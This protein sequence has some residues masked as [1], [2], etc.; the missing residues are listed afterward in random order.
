MIL[1]QSSLCWARC[2]NE[3]S[4][5][6]MSFNGEQFSSLEAPESHEWSC[7]RNV[8]QEQE[9]LVPI[10]KQFKFT[11]SLISLKGLSWI[12]FLCW[13]CNGTL[14]LLLLH[15]LLCLNRQTFRSI[16]PREVLWI[17]SLWRAAWKDQHTHQF[18]FPSEHWSSSSL[19]SGSARKRPLAT[20]G[21]ARLN[22][23]EVAVKGCALD[24]MGKRQIFNFNHQSNDELAQSG[25]SV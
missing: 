6:T 14:K 8:D 7:W 5:R 4:V 19:S 1:F 11:V 3:E 23:I 13:P 2:E 22:C 12:A 9:R 17:P 25:Q 21:L 10:K 18:M 20:R 15:Y 16:F 24:L